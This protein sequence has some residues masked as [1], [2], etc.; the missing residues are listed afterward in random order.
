M[1][2]LSLAGA[3]LALP[4][5]VSTSHSS[6]RTCG[7]PA[8][9][10]RTRPRAFAHGRADDG[11]ARPSLRHAVP[12]AAPEPRWVDRT[13]PFA[14]SVAASCTG[15]ELRPLP[16]AGIT[17]P[18]CACMPSPLARRD[19]WVLRSSRPATAAFPESQ[20]GR[21]PYRPSR[22]PLSVHSRY[23]LHARHDPTP[24]QV[25]HPRSCLLPALPPPG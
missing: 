4:C 10:S 23:G 3:S 2:V 7:F 18:P 5:S 14:R 11:S 15:L 1:P 24:D 6:N 9:G 19:R 16:S 25:W 17:R 21:L 12:P 8:S 20:T 13:M 22:G